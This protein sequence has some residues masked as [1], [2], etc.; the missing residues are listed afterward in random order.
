MKTIG[1][2]FYYAFSGAQAEA[3]APQWGEVRPKAGQTGAYPDQAGWGCAYRGC[4]SEV[5]AQ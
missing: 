4:K 1:L 3:A 2:C 5:L